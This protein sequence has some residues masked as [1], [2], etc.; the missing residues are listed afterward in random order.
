M[1]EIE[2][3]VK[4]KHDKHL[5]YLDSPTEEKEEEYRR[6]RNKARTLSK[7][8]IETLARDL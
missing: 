5:R 1:E 8:L 4:Y 7:K 3:S 6:A 2:E